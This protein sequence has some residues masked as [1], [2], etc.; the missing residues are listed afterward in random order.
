MK[1][2][3]QQQLWYFLILVF[4]FGG[5]YPEERLLNFGDH[6]LLGLSCH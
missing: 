1:C 6:D 3:L 4:G 5:L 2:L